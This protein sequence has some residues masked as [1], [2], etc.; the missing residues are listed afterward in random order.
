MGRIATAPTKKYSGIPC[1]QF[2]N[3]RF[4]EPSQPCFS[5]FDLELGD[6]S[7]IQMINATTIVRYNS[8]AVVQW[9]YAITT[10]LALSDYLAPGAFYYDKAAGKLYVTAVETST[11][12]DTI[13]FISINIAT[14]A[15]TTPAAAQQLSADIV[16]YLSDFG[17]QTLSGNTLTIYGYNKKLSV[18]ITTGVYSSLADMGESEFLMARM[19]RSTTD[20]MTHHN[21]FIGSGLSSAN[22]VVFRMFNPYA[23]TNYGSNQGFVRFGS[24]VYASQLSSGYFGDRS[25]L[26]YFPVADFYR[27][28]NEFMVSLGLPSTFKHVGS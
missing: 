21:M 5:G 26:C 12:P 25:T 27:G 20:N 9:T 19:S 23:S 2:Q 7:Y 6:S 24:Y 8:A 18:D 16:F 14:G 17:W 1:L 11:T 22:G 3:V 10:G 13:R 28:I 4:K 15:G